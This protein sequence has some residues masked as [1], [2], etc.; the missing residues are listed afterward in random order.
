[1]SHFDQLGLSMEIGD[2]EKL[3]YILVTLSGI[4]LF[5]FIFKSHSLI[6]FREFSFYLSIMF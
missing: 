4:V 1:M 3:Y 6:N 5:I 2:D